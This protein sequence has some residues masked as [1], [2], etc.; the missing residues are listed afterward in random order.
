V[1]GGCLGDALI[2][3]QAIRAKSRVPKY[4]SREEVLRGVR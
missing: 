4:H 1:T 3:D 2:Y